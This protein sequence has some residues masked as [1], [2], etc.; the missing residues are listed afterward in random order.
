M[1]YMKQDYAQKILV[2]NLPSAG[3]LKDGI[4]TFVRIDQGYVE[5][6][7]VSIYYDLFSKKIQREVTESAINK[8]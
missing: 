5:G 1:C 3:K 4:T 6:D 7:V 2:K 8:L